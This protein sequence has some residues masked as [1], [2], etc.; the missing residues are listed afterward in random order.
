MVGAILTANE[1]C[2]KYNKNVQRGLHLM[3][4]IVHDLQETQWQDLDLNK[5]L[6][7]QDVVIGANMCID[8]SA[9]IEEAIGK[10]KQLVLISRCVYGGFS[11]FIQGVLLRCRKC[12]GP[13]LELRHGQT[14]FEVKS[15]NKNAFG[16]VCCFYGSHITQEEEQSARIQSVSDGISLQ[17]KG[18][19]ILFYDSMD[20]LKQ[21]GGVLV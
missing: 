15:E 3:K 5:K 4:V 19:K 17:A 21:L 12:F 10:C 20:K 7:G 2:R 11:P 16:M 9:N 6:N 18:V 14:H 1:T 13:F 8:K